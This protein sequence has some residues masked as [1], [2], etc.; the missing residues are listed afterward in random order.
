MKRFIYQLLMVLFSIIF[1]ISGCQKTTLNSDFQKEQSKSAN[2]DVS[3]RTIPNFNLEVILRGAGKAF[4]LVKFR[5][6]N[7]PAKIVT[8][9]TWVRDLQ[10]NT[11]Y[12][13]QRAT[14]TNITD[15]LCLGTNW[16]TLGK[17]PT[18]QVIHTNQEG[19][20]RVELWR[21]LSR[22]Q[23]GA[24]FDIHFRVINPLGGTVLASD[25]YQFTVR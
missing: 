25:C 8:L 24:M 23:S 20:A 12:R 1:T 5:Q 21:D 7:D 9:D 2:S 19:T 17:G 16:L 14:D 22:F 4:G 3:A 13:L 10:P 18:L 6:D 11:D 15:G